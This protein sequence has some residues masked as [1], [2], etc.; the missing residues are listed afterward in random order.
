MASAA[1][2]KIGSLP[3][4]LIVLLPL[5][6]SSKVS[7]SAVHGRVT[8]GGEPLTGGYISFYPEDQAGQS[9]GAPITDG[10]YEVAHVTTGKNRVQIL[11]TE[12]ES[13]EAPT[14]GMSR[15][16][17]NKDRLTHLKPSASARQKPSPPQA[18]QTTFHVDVGA[19]TQNIDF[20]LEKAGSKR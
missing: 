4:I 6:C 1:F 8:L 17:A 18:A 10:E 7:R 20:P 16:D 15:R 11:L 14:G 3:L 12:P 5:G 2:G 19:G 13:Q 9:T